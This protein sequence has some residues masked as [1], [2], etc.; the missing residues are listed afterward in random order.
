M[1][2]RAQ[3]RPVPSTSANRGRI[4]GHARSAQGSD[5]RVGL[6]I[7]PSDALETAAAYLANT[8]EA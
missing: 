1:T 4:R 6:V 8:P 3:A 5:Y 7:A 2:N